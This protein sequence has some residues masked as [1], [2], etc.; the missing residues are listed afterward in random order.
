ML[1]DD[2]QYLWLQRRK[3]EL[4][5]QAFEQPPKT[6]DEF[7]QRLGRWLEVNDHALVIEDAYRKRDQRELQE[8]DDDHE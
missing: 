7:Q 2:P 8:E 5:A 1:I 3:V 6:M 4:Q